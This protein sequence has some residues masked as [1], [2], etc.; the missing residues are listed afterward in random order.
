MKTELLNKLY[1]FY[2]SIFA[3]LSI[4]KKIYIG[5]LGNIIIMVFLITFTVLNIQK[6]HSL[7]NRI[8]KK[9]Y[10]NI[11]T[12]RIIGKVL[13]GMAEKDERIAY[14]YNAGTKNNND[15]LKK[16]F[17]NNEAEVNK[18][19]KILY[20]LIDDSVQKK[21]IDKLKND[22]ITFCFNFRKKMGLLNSK[23]SEGKE[24][25]KRMSSLKLSDNMQKNVKLIINANDKSIEIGLK[26]LGDIERDTTHAEW[27]VLFVALLYLFGFGYFLHSGIRK[28]INILESGAQSISMGEFGK[29]IEIHS[30][31]EFG[32]L[33]SAFNDMSERVKNLDEMKSD[34][35]YIVTHELKTPLTSM[36]EA[37]SLLKEEI[38]GPITEKQ[39]RFLNI[40]EE[41]IERLLDF[42]KSLLDLVKM[43]GGLYHLGSKLTDITQLIADNLTQLTPLI[44]EKKITI[45]KNIPQ[46][47]PPVSLDS[48]MIDR[49]LT[50]LIGNALKY[51]PN[52]GELNI[53]VVLGIGKDM[54][55]SGFILGSLDAYNPAV[56]IFIR[57][58]GPGIETNNLQD[59]FS[60]FYQVKMTSHINH[61]GSGLG[62]SIAKEIMFAHN[63][64]IGVKNNPRQGTCFFFALSLVS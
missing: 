10:K 17:E 52:G 32:R 43:E 64:I 36:K 24:A 44:R 16:V 21:Y 48:T 2:P 62:L 51:S 60:K 45:V 33:A 42:I 41:D 27:V 1:K 61:T 28:P 53:E 56:G 46:Y 29:Q 13:A 25:A 49:V 34:F 19:L 4:S 63:G 35:I 55:A 59:V 12:A 57:D 39:A 14:V 20:T 5:I 26:Q 50:N 8:S 7:A 18:H 47:I 9:N 30:N 37:T 15:R 40:T 22:F 6:F 31:D 23:G 11:N 38:L 58:E 54:M 3:K